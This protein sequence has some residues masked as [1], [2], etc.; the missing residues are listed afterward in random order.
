MKW[1]KIPRK[2]MEVSFRKK[3]RKDKTGKQSGRNVLGEETTF[4][5][6]LR[7]VKVDCFS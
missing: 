7:I 5:L 1:V 3:E 6:K 2:N 4:Q